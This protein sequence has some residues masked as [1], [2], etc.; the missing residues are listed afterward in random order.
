M[1]NE[2]LKVD[3]FDHKYLFK[4]IIKYIRK[5]DRFTNIKGCDK[6]KYVQK[7]I[8]N[9]LGVETYERFSPY[10]SLTIDFIIELSKDKSI[11]D[12]INKKTM[13]LYSLCCLKK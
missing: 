12:D 7:Q 5:V 9:I 1:E 8:A 3:V 13:N 11:L 4:F 2:N 6:K 10:I